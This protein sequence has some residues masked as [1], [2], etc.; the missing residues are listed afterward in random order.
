[1]ESDKETKEELANC[2]EKEESFKV[3][4]YRV[5][6]RN[7]IVLEMMN[8]ALFNVFLT[9]ILFLLFAIGTEVMPHLFHFDINTSPE[10]FIFRGGF[11]G[12]M[13]VVWLVIFTITGFWWAI[14]YQRINIMCIKANTKLNAEF[15]F[16]KIEKIFKVIKTIII[17][18]QFAFAVV[19]VI[20]IVK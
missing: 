2:S 11:Y 19:C 13:C 1:M 12:T 17:I 10:T 3:K 18:G 5:C 4:I 20:M 7:Y 6:K 15:V 16:N 8:L 9:L 14:S